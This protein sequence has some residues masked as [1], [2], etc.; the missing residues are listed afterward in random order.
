[1][2]R[3]G[4][5]T[6][7]TAMVTDREWFTKQTAWFFILFLVKSYKSICMIFFYYMWNICGKNATIENSI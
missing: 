2:C 1:M 4:A 6:E 7:L 5:W 3:K